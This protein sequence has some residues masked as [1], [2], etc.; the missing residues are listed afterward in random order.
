MIAISACF[1]IKMQIS[2]LLYLSLFCLLSQTLTNRGQERNPRQQR[3][4]KKQKE[5]NI[6]V[7]RKAEH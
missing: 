7:L 2:F 1:Q 5:Q 4:R 6:I 3:A